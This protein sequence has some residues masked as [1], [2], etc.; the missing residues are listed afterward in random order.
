MNIAHDIGVARQIGKYS[1]AVEVPGNA[2]LLFLSG[3]PGLG[4]NG[5]LSPNFEEQAEQAWRNVAAALEKAG[6]KIENLVKITQYVVRQEDLAVYRT[7]RERALGGHRPASMLS[8]VVALP[9]PDFL[10]EIEACAAAS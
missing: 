3:T 10:I 7:I 2:R 4:P 5:E 6:M 8:V 9:R 1:D